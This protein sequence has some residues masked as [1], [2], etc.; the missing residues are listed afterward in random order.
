MVGRKYNR[1]GSEGANLRILL[2]CLH[3]RK[4]NEQGRLVRSGC[5]AGAFSEI[6]RKI[7]LNI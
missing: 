6:L 3:K 5:R 1:K 4:R 2:D 7:K